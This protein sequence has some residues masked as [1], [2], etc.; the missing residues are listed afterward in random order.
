[1]TFLFLSIG[2]SL[3]A[4]DYS[5]KHVIIEKNIPAITLQADEDGDGVEDSADTCPSTPAGESVDANGCSQS[6]LDDDNDG[7]ANSIDSCPGTAAG[8]SV[9]ANGCSQSQLD[10]SDCTISLINS[11]GSTEQTITQYESVEPVLFQFETDCNEPLQAKLTAGEFPEGIIWELINNTILIGGTSLGSPGVFEW[12]ITIDN[13]IPSETIDATTSYKING[14]FTIVESNSTLDQ[15]LDGIEDSLDQ[16]PDTPAGESVDANGCGQTQLDDDNDGV[17]NFFDECPETPEGATVD[18][19][20]CVAIAD[21]DLDGVGDDEDQ[22]PGTPLGDTVDENGC[23]QTQLDDD[24]DGVKNFFDICPDTP[25][26]APVDP[27]GCIIIADADGDGV[28]DETDQCD[29]TPYGETVDEVGCSDSQKDDD[30]D[31]VSNLLDQCP[32]TPANTPVDSEG[33]VSENAACAIIIPETPPTEIV[34]CLDQ[35][36]EPV[37]VIVKSNC[38]QPNLSFNSSG[39]PGGLNIET[40]IENNEIKIVLSGKPIEKGVFPVIFTINELSNNLSKLI[41]IVFIV[42]DCS[43]ANPVDPTQSDQDEDG[44]LD[45][46]DECP[47][48]PAGEAVNETGCSE[49]QTSQGTNPTADD[50]NDGVINALDE[51]PDTEDGAS[52]DYRGCSEAQGGQGTPTGDQDNDGVIDLFDECPDTEAGVRVDYKGCSEAQGGETD[53]TA[54]QDNDGVINIFDQCPDTEEGASVDNNGCSVAQG[55]QADPTADEDN[56][57]VINII[58]ECPDT[59]EGESVDY[60]GCSESQGGKGGATDD[61]DNDGVI[62]FIDACPDTAEGA[63]VDPRGC[64]V[65]QGGDPTYIQDSDEDGIIDIIDVCPETPAEEEVDEYGCS[66]AQKEAIKDFDQDGVDDEFDVC[67][68][69]PPGQQV[70][71]SGCSEVDQDKD[72]DGVPDIVDQCPETPVGVYVNAL[73]CAQEEVDQDF[74]GVPND[75]DQCPYSLPGIAVNEVGCSEQQVQEK[76]AVGDDDEDGVIN[77]LDRCPETPAGATVDETGCTPTETNEQEASDSDLDGVK[78]EDDLCPGTERG[79]V[80]NQFGCPLN[81]IDS[82]FDKVTDDVDLCPDT[83]AGEE[84]NEFGCSASQLENDSDMDGVENEKDYCPESPPY[85]EVD[86]NGCTDLQREVDEDFDGVLNGLDQCPDTK[87]F[88][89]VDENGCALEQRDDDQDGVINELDRCPD[90]VAGEKVDPY[91]CAEVEVDGDDDGDGVLNSQDECPGTAA[92]VPVDSYGCPFI[93]PVIQA[94]TFEQKEISRDDEIEEIRVL[95]GKVL[96]EDPN[97]STGEN[98]G[99]SL[100]LSYD[101][102]GPLFELEDDSIYLIDRIDFEEGSKRYF[103]IIATNDKGQSSEQVMTLNVLDIPNTSSVSKFEVAVFNVQNEASGAK[104]DHTRYLVPKIDK[105]VGKW[106]IKKKIVGGNDAHLF[107]VKS[108][109]TA[110]D[111]KGSTDIDQDDYLAF[112][113]TPN[114]EEPMDHNQDNIY[115]VEV[116]NINT[117]DGEATQ[118]ISIVQTN[119]I[120]P[121]NDQTAIQFQTVPVNATDDSDGDGVLDILDNSPFVANPNQEDSDGDG[122]GDVTDDADHDGVLNPNDIC[123]D[124]P[125][126][127]K[128]N[129]SGCPIFYLPANQ[130]SITTSEKCIGQNGITLYAIESAMSY[131]VNLSGPMNET[132]AWAEDALTFTEVPNGT[133]NICITVDGIDPSEFERCY[134]VTVQEPQPLSVYS[135]MG[136][137]GKTVNY[138]LAGGDIY[139]ITHNGE[140]FQTEES[141]LDITLKEGINSIVITTGVECQGVFEKNYFNSSSVSFSP[142]PFVDNLTVYVGGSDNEITLEIY[143]TQGQLVRHSVYQLSADQRMIQLNTSNLRPGGYII[144]SSGATTAQSELIIKR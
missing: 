55:G 132:Y 30:E 66:A 57:G 130:F 4:N 116:V 63:A 42:D 112:I 86:V 121:E 123:A 41:S 59:P 39:L 27:R 95:L 18:S 85:T 34:Y 10:N 113:T 19:R 15:D 133:Y 78:N 109:E 77:I 120:V 35:D 118:P 97:S 14:K 84:V 127:T 98:N 137:S 46:Y 143:T 80:V 93:P 62:N 72:L 61:E 47:D 32:D 76:E 103:K 81:N 101:L 44:V 114:F 58:D 111:K 68:N 40:A 142:N 20:G 9:D 122:I 53:P 139:T 117:N 144:K 45:I 2:L 104:V 8:E 26:G 134:S 49:S 54:D 1:M 38:E 3:F 91:G 102:D 24:N 6:Q 69:T 51:C 16:C 43:G 48:T 22:C 23:G 126:D 29:N 31:G 136:S 11:Q 12:E 75:V 74:D 141:S 64:S 88:A 56:D 140:S 94:Q 106:K 99:I 135:K 36:I 128:V 60:L 110:T 87:P 115:E 107:E 131:T 21:E 124:T 7:V 28:E 89:Q 119:I 65:E 83:P 50:D 25:E 92:G 129:F 79:I 90:T 73:G 13:S 108:F 33:C 37:E 82:D 17:V 67:P 70:D 105:G 5:I 96:Y 100:E 125:L 52:V 71:E 138:Q